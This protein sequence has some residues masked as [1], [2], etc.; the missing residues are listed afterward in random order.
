LRLA[1]VSCLPADPSP[2]IR[3]Q[4]KPGLRRA[5]M[6]DGLVV[7]LSLG[8]AD[9]RTFHGRACRRF[10]RLVA[11]WPPL[12]RKSEC[13]Q[14]D[15]CARPLPLPNVMAWF[16]ARPMGGA[17]LLAWLRTVRIPRELCWKCACDGLT[18]VWWCVIT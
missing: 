17:E 15:G 1:V 6:V 13:F 8:P 4:A 9:R 12:H 5:A 7:K 16:R 11:F 18:H 10:A 3:S 14:G 2:D